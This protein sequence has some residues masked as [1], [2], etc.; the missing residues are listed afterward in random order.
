MGLSSDRG[1]A[2]YLSDGGHFE[3]LGLYEMVR[4]RCRY[5]V[6]VDA[7]ADPDSGFADLGNAVLK[8]RVDLNIDID[9]VPA[10]AIGSRRA[11]LS[12][13]YWFAHGQILYP[14]G[15]LG[16]IIYLKASD[17]PD[18][19]MDVRAYRNAHDSFPHQ[20]TLDQ[21]FSE[22]QFES[23]RALGLHIAGVTMSAW[24]GGAG[25][26][27]RQQSERAFEAVASN[28]DRL[29]WTAQVTHG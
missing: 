15:A 11:P 19:P 7:G 8:I 29:R 16:E 24:P 5:I 27:D 14:E 26:F 9:F 1:R 28:L 17:L 20:P 12:P 23:Y 6:V 3:N 21:F 13:F 18:M 10:V 4:R 25:L 22:S 2:V